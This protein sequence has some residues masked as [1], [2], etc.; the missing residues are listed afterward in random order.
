LY[1]SVVNPDHSYGIE[2]ALNENTIRTIIGIYKNK[3]KLI[4][5]KDKNGN[6]R[7]TAFM[8]TPL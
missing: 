8:S 6:V 1:H 7:H 4:T 2:D 5:K 3:K